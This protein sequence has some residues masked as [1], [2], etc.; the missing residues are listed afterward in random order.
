MQSP[1]LQLKA[2]YFNK[3]SVLTR[4][5]SELRAVDRVDIDLDVLCRQREDDPLSW[6]V[7]LYVTITPMAGAKAP[8]SGDFEVMGTFNIPPELS[9]P[10]AHKLV[11]INGA[12]ILYGAV[13][14]MLCMITSRTFY[15]SLLLPTVSFLNLY[16]EHE[17]AGKQSAA[18]VAKQEPENAQSVEPDKNK[19]A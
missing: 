6:F 13:R 7:F 2:C 12:T 14:E 15:A 5:E 8:F 3:V 10:S 1:P 18:E 16:Q 4:P 19:P 11:Y 17:K 9:G